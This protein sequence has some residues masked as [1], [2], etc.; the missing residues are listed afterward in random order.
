MNDQTD[1]QITERTDRQTTQTLYL[2]AFGGDNIIDASTVFRCNADNN[3]IVNDSNMRK[4]NVLISLLKKKKKKMV[5]L[6]NEQTDE[7][8]KYRSNEQNNNIPL[9]SSRLGETPTPRGVILEQPG[10]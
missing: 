3:G 10:M 2:S 9:T 6:T 1:R 7:R 8:T 4:V 5:E